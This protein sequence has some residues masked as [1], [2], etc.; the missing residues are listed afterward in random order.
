M[1]LYILESNKAFITVSD[2]NFT[3]DDIMGVNRG[4]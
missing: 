2:I 4:V 3:F 1:C